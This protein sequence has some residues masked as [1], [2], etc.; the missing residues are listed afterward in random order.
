[1]FRE[2]LSSV[3]QLISSCHDWAT[4][5][6]SG[7]QVDVVFLD[8]SKS[9]DE[10]SH[11]RISVKLSYYGINGSTLIW[12]NYFIRNRVQ[13][14]SIN[15]SHSTWV[16][17]SSGVPQGPVLGPALFHSYIIDIREKIQ[18]N[19]CLYADDTTVCREINSIND[20]NILHEDLDTV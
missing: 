14:V 17:V 7:G 16:N 8:A 20:H 1:M 3:A 2:K 11:R 18:S 9:F 4:A 12:I 15:G 10:V 19:I 13:S 6:Q 5:I